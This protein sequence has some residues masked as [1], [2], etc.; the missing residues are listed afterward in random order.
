[1][2]DPLRLTAGPLTVIDRRA[3]DAIAAI[4]ALV[5]E[6]DP[7]LIVVGLPVSLRGGEGPAAAEARRFGAEV[8][9]ATGRPVVYTDE[10][11]TTRTAEQAML[12]GGVKRRDR[13]TRVDKVAAA[14]IL[15]QF[16]EKR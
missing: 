1:V 5:E 9:E 12:D 4:R 13:R 7:D 2:S 3:G 8:G 11:F 6:Y 16:L 14:V 15:Q 10:R